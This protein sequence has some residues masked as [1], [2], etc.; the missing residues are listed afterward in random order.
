LQSCRKVSVR[1]NP[2][3]DINFHAALTDF[4]TLLTKY[5]KS[6]KFLT[7]D[8]PTFIDFV[9]ASYIDMYVLLTPQEW[10]DDVS[11]WDGGRWKQLS[12]A[13]NEAVNS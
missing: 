4:N 5:S 12:E 2:D 7:G 6:R 13:C 3:F 10:V 1:T 9:V 8:E 11:K